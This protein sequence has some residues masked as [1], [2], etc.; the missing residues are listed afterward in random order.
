MRSRHVLR[1]FKGF[2]GFARETRSYWIVPLFVLL[3][4]MGALIVGTEVAAP[5]IYAL[6]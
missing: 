5:L 6:F 1:L 2:T 3:G 4:L